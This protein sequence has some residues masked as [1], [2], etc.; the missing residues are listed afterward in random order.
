ME[1]G[2]S[3]S[4][5]A[6]ANVEDTQTD[7]VDSGV[8]GG[9][10]APEEASS[11]DVSADTLA[12]TEPETSPPDAEPDVVD[13]G[14]GQARCGA[15][16][17]DWITSPVLGDVLETKQK[18]PHSVVELGLA[19]AYFQKEGEFKTKRLPKHGTKAELI[20]YQTQD[21]GKLID[22]TALLTYPSS[23]GTYP[24]LLILHGT[25]G[26]TDK[27]APTAGMVGADWGGF[28]EELGV[29]AALYAS[30]GYIVVFP[31]YIGLKSFGSPTGFLHPYLV[32]E[33]TAIASLD[34]VR[35]TKKR[36]ASSSTVPGDVVVIGG[37]QGGHAAAFVNRYLPHY[38]PELTIKGSVWDV[39]PTD[40]T[41][42][43][44]AALSV[45]W[46]NATKNAIAFFAT[47]N[48]WYASA[49]GG[50]SEILLPPL[51]T[52][53]PAS[54]ASECKGTKFDDPTL[55]K[56]FTPQVL[57]AA[58]EPDFGTFEPWACYMK[59]SSLSS[60]S[61]PRLDDIPS[62]FLLGEKDA[63]V[64]NTVERAAFQELCAQ[65]LKLVYLE[66]AGATHTKPL[67]WAF[68]QTLDFLEDRLNGK[69]LPADTCLLR[70]AETCTSQP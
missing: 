21:R 22:A 42:Q 67:V 56:V 52:E 31:D 51:D 3:G 33:P 57:A 47:S 7:V 53:V 27:C 17:Y 24:I 66:C 30:F 69:P 28:E 2:S 4:S 50:L 9:K 45:S 5:G 38:A 32:A 18:A 60:T 37:S 43:S 49:P 34:S 10:D 20:R 62:M 1:G 64:N 48:E 15:T 70:A 61:V 65:G 6:D 11:T 54:M 55:E 44:R 41:E 46:E 63:L 36:L 29:L 16:P 13:A 59:E 8:E 19:V 35:A 12:D 25:A 23:K 58:K 39:P 40:L 26:F 68:D 14:T